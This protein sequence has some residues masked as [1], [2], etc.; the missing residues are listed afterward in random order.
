LNR[1]IRAG[2]LRFARLQHADEPQHV[3]DGFGFR[4]VD[5]VYAA[6][7]HRGQ[8]IFRMSG[9]QRVDPHQNAFTAFLAQGLEFIRG[10]KR[11]QFVARVL[12]A[13]LQNRIFQ[14]EADR[15]GLAAQGFDK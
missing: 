9:I 4:D 5:D 3:L 12:F 6:R 7:A 1:G 14:I 8:I 2:C 11:R 13:R 10:E 15:V